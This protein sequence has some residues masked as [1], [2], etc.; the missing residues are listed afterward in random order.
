MLV[1]VGI[2]MSGQLVGDFGYMI[3][4]INELSLRQTVITERMLGRVNASLN[5]LVGGVVPIGAILAGL[6]SE[7]IGI[8]PTLLIGASGILLSTAWLFFSPIR[9]LR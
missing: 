6:L 8:R 9:R 3:A 4:C 2:L 7:Y 1:I 5:F